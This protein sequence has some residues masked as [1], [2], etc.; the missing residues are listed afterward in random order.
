MRVGL[1]SDTHIAGSVRSMPEGIRSAFAGVELILHAGDIYELSALD[2]LE[3]IAPVYAVVGNGVEAQLGHPRLAPRHVL[4]IAGMRVAMTHELR[5]PPMLSEVW[6]GT[7]AAEF[8][9]G[10]SIRQSVENVFG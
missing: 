3:E 8:P 4:E 2:W 9:A 1:V 5:L 10:V 6:P 7:I